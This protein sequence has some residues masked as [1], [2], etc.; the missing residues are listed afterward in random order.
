MLCED[1]ENTYMSP[2]TAALPPPPTSPAS[3]HA[4]CYSHLFI[5]TPPSPNTH[6]YPDPTHICLCVQS[7]ISQLPICSV[8]VSCLI[9]SYK[10]DGI[11][12]DSAAS[13]A[14][15]SIALSGI[16]TA[17]GRIRAC[18]VSLGLG[19]AVFPGLAW[20]SRSAV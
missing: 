18:S 14:D 4:K 5:H 10:P 16:Y 19:R 7:A 17:G 3:L 15:T 1:C 9:G 13:N 8:C 20:N 2:P 11:S 6:H 12:G